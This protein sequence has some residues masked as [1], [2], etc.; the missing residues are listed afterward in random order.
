[1][2]EDQG[3]SG[4]PP[5]DWAATPPSVRA[6]VHSLLETVQ[7]LQQS[8]PELQRRIPEL[9]QRIQDLESRLNQNSHNSSQPPSRDQKPNRA[10]KKR[11][12]H[13]GAKPGHPKA[14]RPLSD[15]PDRIL[16][17]RAPTCAHCH[18][19]LQHVVP[20][21]VIRRQVTELPEVRPVIIETRQ[22]EVLCPVCQQVQCGT[23]P[24]GLE[25]TRQFG[26]RLEATIVYLQHQQHLSYERTTQALHD[27]FDVHVSEGGQACIIE[28]AGEAAQPAAATIREQIQQSAVVGSD[29]TGARVEGTTWWQW[30]FVTTTAIYH[31]IRPSRGK[32]VID[33]VMGTARAEV[34][35]CDC[36][37]PQLRAPTERLQL[38][39]VHQIRN[40]QGL[41]ERCPRLRWAQELQGLFREA[42][43]LHH[44]RAHLT[45]RGWQ[46]R[47]TE[48]EHRLER[49][50]ARRLRQPAAQALYRRYHKYREA[51]F[52]FLH[53]ERV[54]FQNS[55]CERALR[56]AVI[57]RKVSGGF[58]SDW[59]AEAYAAL[60]SVIDTARLQG[61]NVFQT[62]VTL[63]GQPVLPFLSTVSRE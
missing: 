55:A 57:H 39:L 63:M 6:L 17:V 5:E 42:I 34:W 37:K 1:M 60:A 11:R 41:I 18:A 15:H 7:H 61:R 59:G 36:W 9:Q 40:L 30:V 62:L 14:E 33:A 45:G 10:E 26:P 16:E 21:R 43:H 44:R 50:L 28:R 54:P 49:L 32:D 25:A 38:C 24:E 51:L 31:V 27:L 56:P 58:R 2:S 13:R 35:L 3:P 20:Q 22:A 29:E 4:I 48:L 19:D 8:L 53:D 52:V 12:R 23:L 46:R 47:V